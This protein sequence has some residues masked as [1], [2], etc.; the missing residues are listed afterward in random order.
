MAFFVSFVFT[1]PI[2]C[3]CPQD[4][5]AV[6]PLEV[7]EMDRHDFLYLVRGTDI[8]ERL[9][10]LAA[11]RDQPSWDT[12]TANRVLSDL[13]SNQKSQLQVREQKLHRDTKTHIALLLC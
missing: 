5:E 4:V 6:T 13:S 8:P 1:D 3:L 10:R 9:R 12:I 7:L 2:I 11:V